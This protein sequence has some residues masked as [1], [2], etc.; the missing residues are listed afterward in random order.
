VNTRQ[1]LASI[2]MLDPHALAAEAR[3]HPEV[4]DRMRENLLVMVDDMLAAT[5]ALKGALAVVD[6]AQQVLAGEGPRAN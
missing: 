5:C 4:F 2:A 1:Y 3:A 6:A